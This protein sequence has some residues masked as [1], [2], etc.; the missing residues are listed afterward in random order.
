MSPRP[1]LKQCPQRQDAFLFSVHSTSPPPRRV[2]FPPT[3]TLTSTYAAHSSAT[4]DRSPVSVAPNQCAL[5]GRHEREFVYSDDS[6]PYQT[7][8]IKGGYF[9]PRA[10]EACAPEPSGHTYYIPRSPLLTPDMSSASDEPDRLVTPP[11]DTMISRIS[12]RFT[13]ADSMI[14]FTRHTQDEIDTPFS[15]LQHP[16]QAKEKQRKKR[17]MRR[18]GTGHLNGDH[19]AFAVPS[20]D[21]DSCLGGF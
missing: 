8:E 13:S 3:P 9:H 6:Q 12:V 2:H 4:Y 7:A 20:L 1:I 14:P 15:L 5:P 16:S 18:K 10:Y 11:P 17:S 19:A 21:Y